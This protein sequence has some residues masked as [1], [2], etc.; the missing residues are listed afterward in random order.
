MEADVA[1]LS[2]ELLAERAALDDMMPQ[3]QARWR[4]TTSPPSMRCAARL[5]GCW[6]ADEDRRELALT[7]KRLEEERA[8]DRRTMARM[9]ETIEELPRARE[10]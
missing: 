7:N 9:E 5:L 8:E 3:G 10:E 1:R 2:E 4:A 6:K